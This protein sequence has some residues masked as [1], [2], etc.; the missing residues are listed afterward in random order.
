VKSLA[1]SGG[2]AANDPSSYDELLPEPSSDE[3]GA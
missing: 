1:A 3:S 2:D